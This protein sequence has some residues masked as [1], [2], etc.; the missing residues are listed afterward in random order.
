MI[1]FENLVYITDPDL[2]LPRGEIEFTST[3]G[4]GA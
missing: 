1:Y 2:I 4:S 3:G